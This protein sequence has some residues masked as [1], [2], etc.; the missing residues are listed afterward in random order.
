MRK[1]IYKV[2]KGGM[3][4]QIEF[5]TDRTPQWTE[6]QYTRHRYTTVMELISNEEAE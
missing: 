3:S 4:E 2:T 1:L 5:I 6:A